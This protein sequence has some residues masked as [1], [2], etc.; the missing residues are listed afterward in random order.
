MTFPFFVVDWLDSALNLDGWISL[1]D[2]P[3]VDVL[4]IRSVGWL[5]K[6]NDKGIVIAPNIAHNQAS[7][8][9]NIPKCCII[10]MHR[11]NLDSLAP[12]P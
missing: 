9:I 8:L 12:A 10:Q 2:I 3:E 7:E 6:E 5:L 1:E 11:L 4:P